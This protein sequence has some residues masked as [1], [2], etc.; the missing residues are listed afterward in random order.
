MFE[1]SVKLFKDE[2]VERFITYFITI[3][4]SAIADRWQ[5][6]SEF[7][8]I[9]EAEKDEIL[10]Q[11]NNTEREYPPDKSIEQLFEE[12]VE[13]TPDY[14]ALHGCMIA[15]MDGEVGAAP[16]VCPSL[17]VSLTYRQL[18]EQSNRLAG[19][20]LEK[21][22]V[23]DAVVGMMIER[24]VEM[25]IG[26]WGILKA[27][28]VYLPIDP[29][30][31]K[32]RI[33]YM[34]FDSG[35]SI[36]LTDYEAKTKINCQLSMVNCQ[37]STEKP[38]KDFRPSSGIF[39]YLIYTSGSTGKPKGA[40]IEKKG[41]LNLLYWY[42]EEL[43]M[44]KEDNHLLIAPVS[45]DLAQKNLFSPL[46]SGGR[47]TLA[48]P[49][50]PDYIELKKWISKER[51]SVINCAP[52]VF[53]PLVELELNEEDDFSGLHSL[54]AV[55]LGG[56][57]IRVERLLPW[58]HSTAFDCEIFNTYGPTE[59]TDIAT[60]YRLKAKSIGKEDIIPI[61][62]PVANVKVYVLDKYLQVLPVRIPG[63]LCIGGIGV[64]QGYYHNKEL[65]D[66]RFVATPHLPVKRIYRTGDL[67]RWLPDG[68]PAGGATRG[69]IEFLGRIDQQ[70]KA[71]C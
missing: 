50:I 67:T 23:A 46:L 62:K 45:F 4:N 51:I 42:M 52:S 59:C 43:G 71:N 6:I 56:E 68:P 28:G 10:Y 44:G 21:G 40:M 48:L 30:Y 19:H 47:L 1:Y 22:V 41:F 61:G 33:D 65:T 70:V 5:K 32:E 3:L 26:I 17:D 63:E 49:G 69:T 54:R 55:V 29:G 53:Y 7:V 38:A 16:R 58:I 18:N 36:L 13:Q 31:P 15:W 34:L 11:F 14:I 9:T 39:I 24:S 35:A 8:I 64:S 37:W 57:P 2:T 25:I 27:G 66:E 12:Q 60:C 20:L